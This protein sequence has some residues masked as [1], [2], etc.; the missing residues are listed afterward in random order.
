M[1]GHGVGAVFAEVLRVE[2]GGICRS[3]ISNR[4]S[5]IADFQSPIANRQSPIANRQS[6]I[7]NRQPLA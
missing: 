1:A 6:P 7:A 2:G 3:P 4:Q 5:P